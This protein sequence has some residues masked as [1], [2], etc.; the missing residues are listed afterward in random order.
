MD[1]P[2]YQEDFPKGP[3]TEGTVKDHLSIKALKGLPHSSYSIKADP[4]SAVLPSA[5]P[6]NILAPFLKTVGGNYAGENNIDGGNVQ[7]YANS[8]TSKFLNFFDSF[9]LKLR[10]NY[11]YLPTKYGLLTGSRIVDE[12]LKAMAE[13]VSQL[14]SSTFTSLAVNSFAVR[15]N[16]NMGS[17]TRHDSLTAISPTP[18]T[19]NA[20]V[21]N[22]VL[23]GGKYVLVTDDNK[24]SL[25][26]TAGTTTAYKAEVGIYTEPA[27]VLYLLSI[28]YQEVLQEILGVM[29]VHNSFRLKQGTAI[30]DAWSREVPILNAF[31]GLM[32][33]SAFLNLLES[34]NLSFEGEYVDRDFMA[35]MNL[36]TLMPSRRSN[37]I[38][39]PTLEIRADLDHPSIFEVYIADTD[40]EADYDV[41]KVKAGVTPFFSDSDLQS[42][43]YIGGSPV[44]VSIWDACANLKDML[45]LKST[46]EWARSSYTSGGL[47]TTDTARYNTIKSYFDV[48]ID[49]F[50]KF[51]P[52]FADYRECLDTMTRTGTINWFKG[53]R[54]SVTRETDAQLFQN[55]VVDDIYKMVMSGADEITFNSLTKRWSTFSQW[56]IYTGVPE[57]DVKQGGAFISFSA[58]NLASIGSTEGIEYLPIMFNTL[59]NTSMNN[60]IVEGVSRDGRV[61]FIGYT[62][63]TMNSVMILTRLAP[64]SS[65]SSLKIRVPTLTKF[66]SGG[67]DYNDFSD[68]HFSSLYKTLTQIFGV[69]KIRNA[70]SGAYDYGLDPDLLSIYQI[71]ISDI[72]NSVITYARANAPFKGTTSEQG[73]LG[74]FGMSNGK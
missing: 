11:R 48:I 26:I 54:P 35:Q 36:L 38:T 42:T 59:V 37:S 72:T 74:F 41:L 2:E 16:M 56:N 24:S 52:K 40:I 22:Y 65:Q 15:T 68:A 19:L 43:I 55:L 61:C 28:Y 50:V 21:G 57:Y 9:V 32:N 14:Q 10:A 66:A 29:N 64:L 30:R 67:T 6:Y 4:Y 25:G 58:K 12:N 71:E 33:K 60:S 47:A 17:R 46:K 69:A 51:K 44:T 8:E 34:I 27:D 7:Q 70:K 31:F 45:T 23:S 13:A 73:I 39:D 49:T 18:A 63:E 3:M 5:A 20:Y 1:K 62:A 53:F